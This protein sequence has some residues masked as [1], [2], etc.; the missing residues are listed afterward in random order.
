MVGFLSLLW[1]LYDYH[2]IIP[3]FGYMIEPHRIAAVLWTGIVSTVVAIFLQGTALKTASATDAAITFST[4]P[5]W[6]SL[7][8]LALLNEQLEPSIYVGGAIVLLACLVGSLTDI[9]KE[10]SVSE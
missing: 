2:G 6:A 10:E 8:G 1:V 5:V 9:E 4:E 7:F 3:N